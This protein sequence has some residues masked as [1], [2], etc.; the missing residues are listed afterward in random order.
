MEY[1]GSSPSGCRVSVR[2]LFM[3]ESISWVSGPF[4]LCQFECLWEVVHDIG[5]KELWEFLD[6]A[7]CE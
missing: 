5:V 3:I 4:Q 7:S 6:C 1:V 2:N